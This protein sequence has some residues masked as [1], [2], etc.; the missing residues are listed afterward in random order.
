MA[1][2]TIPRYTLSGD[3]SNN[4]ATAF[5]G[6]LTTATADFTGVSANHQLVFTANATN[7]GRIIGVHF[8]AIGTNTQSVA[9]IYIN[10][11][12]TNATAT[13]NALIGQLTLPATTTTNV[14]AVGSSDYYFPNGAGDLNPGFKV[15]AGLGTTVAAGW[16]ATP[17]QGG[18]F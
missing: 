18:Q 16:I 5:A 1:A 10:N 13:N 6:T 8:E 9:R 14:A 17:I 15:Y 2:N 11:G 7:G 12:S 4:N 3:Y